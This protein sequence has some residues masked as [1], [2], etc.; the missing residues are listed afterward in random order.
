M[1]EECPYRSIE[2][3]VP[4]YQCIRCHWVNRRPQY[5]WILKA[6]IGQISC[7]LS[8]ANGGSKW[9]MWRIHSSSEVANSIYKSGCPANPVGLANPNVYS[10]LSSRAGTF[11]HVTICLRVAGHPANSTCRTPRIG[12]VEKC[13]R[14]TAINPS[15]NRYSRNM[16]YSVV[17][18]AFTPDR[19]VL[20]RD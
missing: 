4:S 2:F 20:T 5:I 16:I 8:F 18:A 7:C 19:T 3:F 1:N 12:W 17:F 15:F 11:L 14:V 9:I 13:A 6:E 10:S